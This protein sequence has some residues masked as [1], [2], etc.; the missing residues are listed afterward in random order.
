MNPKARG[1][2]GER[3]AIGELAKWDI[4]V[5]IPLTDNLPWDF[6]LIHK[7]KLFRTQV[8]SSTQTPRDC[9]GSTTFD[10]SSNNWYKRTTKV[11]DE[12]D[13]DVMLLCD[14]D[15]VY[16]LQI[17]EF[18]NRR[19]FTIRKDASRNGQKKGMNFHDDYVISEKRIAE[20]LQ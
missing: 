11:Y 19:A 6:V 14:Y 16:L 18:R 20:V 17:E 10:L 12:D 13:C 15:N 4:D 2:K 9:K 7:G 1:E 3:I 5:A 8:K